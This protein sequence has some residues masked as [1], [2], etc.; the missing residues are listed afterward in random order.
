MKRKIAAGLLALMLSGMVLAAPVYAAETLGMDN[1]EITSIVPSQSKDACFSVGGK[2]YDT[3]ADAVQ[4]ADGKK[5]IVLRGD[6][7]ES[8]T[9]PD[10]ASAVV[11]GQGK[12]TIGDVSVKKGTDLTL[13]NLTYD[14]GQL[15]LYGSL[16]MKNCQ[17]S[18]RQRSGWLIYVISAQLTMEQCKCIDSGDCGICLENGSE[19]TILSCVFEN[20]KASLISAGSESKIYINNTT[21]SGLCGLTNGFISVGTSAEAEIR[22]SKIISTAESSDSPRYNLNFN[23]AKKVVLDN[24]TAEGVTNCQITASNCD[25]IDIQNCTFG[26]S[27]SGIGIN[28]CNRFTYAG[29]QLDIGLYQ[30]FD[31][32][33]DQNLQYTGAIQCRLQENIFTGWVFLNGQKFYYDEEHNGVTGWQKI[34]QRWYHFTDDGFVE[35]GW[36]R[37]TDNK[38][39]YL[40][41]DNGIMQTGWIRDE[42][43]WYLLGGD[44]AMKTGW[45][46][47][48]GKW[49]YLT[50]SGAMA[51][52]R[53][54]Q[55]G[56]KWYY[57]GSDGAMLTNTRVNGYRLDKNGVWVS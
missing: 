44:G 37:D 48:G 1:K 6:V 46:K 32:C 8:L 57:V 3:F 17:I 25:E 50:G 13:E 26:P 36:F 33:Y 35:K 27:R 16:T 31:L 11:D 41:S 2:K 55:T 28:Q 12:Y 5:T 47:S 15:W 20:A 14:G 23:K 54:I 10:G 53:W 56:G 49:Y 21:I 40:K 39:Y 7:T 24:L 4:V 22:N 52:N 51:E 29:N 9:M 18:D 30:T 45:Q 43:H 34:E 42:S 19:A 38:W